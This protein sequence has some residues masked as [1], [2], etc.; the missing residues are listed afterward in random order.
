MPIYPDVIGEYIT[1]PERFE[2]DGLQYIATFEPPALNMGGQTNLILFLQSIVDTQLSVN[3]QLS[4]PQVGTLRTHPVLETKKP[5]IDFKL[6]PAEVG[7]L[8]VPLTTTERAKAG[9]YSL[10]LEFKVDSVRSN[11][12]RQPSKSM[13]FP[14]ELIDDLVGLNLIGVMGARYSTKNG[15]RN[16]LD[17][18]ISETPDP[19]G[20][21]SLAH[22]Y[23][24]LWTV[25][26]FESMAR[27][28]QHI[29]DFRVPIVEDLRPE[30]LFVALYSE[31]QQRFADAGLPLRVGEAIAVGKILTYTVQYFL[32]NHELQNGLLCP[33]WRLAYAHDVA[34]E[35]TLTI[36][37]SLGYEHIM[38]LSL[39]MCFGLMRQ[40]S[41]KMNWGIDERR[42]V[43]DFVAESLEDG[44]ALE[45]DF[46]YL[47]LLIGAASVMQTLTL[48]EEDVKQSV[49]LLVQARRARSE[50][51]TQPDMAQADQLYEEILQK[52]QK[53]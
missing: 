33:I 31:S 34:N 2:A 20:L 36:L 45:P 11:R 23:R 52:A 40:A 8:I 7:L 3:L 18:T 12:V 53:A 47:P 30:P 32:K 42:Q 13:P 41:Q 29:N 26:E 35:G 6:A 51:F 21:D 17:I 43:I 46:L 48:P 9:T 49:Q 24:S 15:R 1:A 27:A 50:V 22:T 28:Q 38:R 4:I 14:N 5:E 44:T 37:R 10:G 39:A 25:D 16:R 19:D